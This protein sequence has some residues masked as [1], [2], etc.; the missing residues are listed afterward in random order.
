[1]FANTSVSAHL[2]MGGA[3][4]F[5]TILFQQVTS[6]EQDVRNLNKQGILCVF[7]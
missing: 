7:L 5:F 4:C 6:V 3:W 1:M 2:A